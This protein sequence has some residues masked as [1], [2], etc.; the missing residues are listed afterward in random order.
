MRASR[1]SCSA[2]GSTRTPPAR[3]RARG[4]RAVR[5]DGPL[6]PGPRARGRGGAQRGRARSASC[7]T[8]SS[9]STS[10]RSAARRWSAT[11]AS[12]RIAT[13]DDE[14]TIP[15]TYVPARNTVFLSLALAGPRCSAPKRIVIGV[16]ALDYSGY[17]DCRPE[18]LAAFERLAALATKA[19]VEGRPLHV[20]R[21]AAAPVEGRHHPPGPGARPRLRPDPQLLRSARR[22]AAPCGR[23][24][25]CLLRAS[26]FAEAGVADPGRRRLN[27]VTERLY[28]TDSVADRVRCPHRAPCDVAGRP[29]RCRPRS[30]RVLSDVRRPA[31]RHRHARRRP[32]RRRQSSRTTARSC[33]SSTTPLA[34]DAGARCG[35]T[36]RAAS[37]TCSS[38]PAS[39]CCRRRSIGCLARGPRASTSA[40]TRRRSTSAARY[41][42]EIA[43]AED[44]ANRVVWDDRPVT[45][46]FADA[47]EAARLPLRKESA[48]EGTLRLIDVDGF[49]PVGVRR[50]ARRAHR[51]DRHHRDCRDR[52]FQGR[53]TGRVRLRRPGAPLPSPSARHRRRQRRVAVGA[54][55]RAAG[56]VERVQAEAKELRRQIKD[57]QTRLAGHEAAALAEAALVGPSYR[58]A[59][60]VARG[61]GCAGR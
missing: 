16:N 47:A 23:C 57:S 54:A 37:I 20:A 44:E 5:A 11:A 13:L 48:R 21:A 60:A 7:G 56:S 14:P 34:G 61:V 45:I 2:A 3:W 8:S 22:T 53:V 9:T 30:H 32:G 42:A 28:Y 52:A 10:R 41:P 26:G 58:A 4:L 24:D 46:R 18:Y 29:A 55:P 1:R 35:S 51:R 17:P 27:T 40:P 59:I 43:A 49:R 19:G 36:G 38:T 33:T 39:T 6:R 15:S 50:H 31:V 25:S 12:R